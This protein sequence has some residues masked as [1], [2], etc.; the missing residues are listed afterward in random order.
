MQTFTTRWKPAHDYIKHIKINTRQRQ[1]QEY[2]L[3]INS[4]IKQ[5]TKNHSCQI[6]IISLNIHSIYIIIIKLNKNTILLQ[7]YLAYNSKSSF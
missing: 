1:E 4:A 3:M 6:Y 2:K 7:Q 5:L